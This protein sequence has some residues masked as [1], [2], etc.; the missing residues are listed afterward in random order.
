MTPEQGASAAKPGLLELGGAFSEAPQTL[1]RA[2]RMGLSGWAF[3]VA[4]RGGALGDV[5]AETVAAAL[6]FIAPEAVADGWDAARQVTPPIEVATTTL[7]ECCRWGAE[8]LDGFPRV[9]RLVELLRRVVRAADPAGMP[10]FAAW[11]ALGEPDDAPGAQAAALLHQLRE[12]RGA[13]HLLAVRASGLTPLEAILAGPEGE[14]GAVA[15]GWQPPYPPAGPLIRRRLWAEAVTDR[16][17]GSAFA[18]LEP[19]ERAEL[20]GL[21]NC[22]VA[23]LRSAPTPACA[24]T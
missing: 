17:T 18:A 20:V 16:I 12:Y 8:H 21:L 10:L 1:R 19:T 3:Y 13:A 6:G 15:F 7:D 22:A 9:A 24:R 11:R 23:G 4:G 5:P 2:R 14:A